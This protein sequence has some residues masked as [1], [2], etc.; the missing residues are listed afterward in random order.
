MYAGR[1]ALSILSLLFVYFI[2]IPIFNYVLDTPEV[3]G[4]PPSRWRASLL[5]A[6][7]IA[8]SVSPSI[9][10]DRGSLRVEAMQRSLVGRFETKLGKWAD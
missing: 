8:Y 2:L 10:G 7:N 4:L 1:I 3:P 9:L 5:S 6:C